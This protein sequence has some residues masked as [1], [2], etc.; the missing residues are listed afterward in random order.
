MILVFIDKIF[1]YISYYKLAME[2]NY[3]YVDENGLYVEIY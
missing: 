2:R 3:E 1:T